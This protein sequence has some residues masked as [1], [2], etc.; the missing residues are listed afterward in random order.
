M[1]TRKC[2]RRVWFSMYVLLDVDKAISG[3]ST[4]ISHV[5]QYPRHGKVRLIHIWYCVIRAVQL[6]LIHRLCGSKNNWVWVL[7]DKSL[8]PTNLFSLI[9]LTDWYMLQFF[10]LHVQDFQYSGCSETIKLKINEYS[11]FYCD[12]LDDAI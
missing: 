2:I 11:I 10:I 4:S 6:L 3:K 1:H 5:C 12:R 9:Q 7:S 8:I